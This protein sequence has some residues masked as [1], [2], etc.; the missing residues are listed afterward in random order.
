M[1]NEILITGVKVT[2]QKSKAR[3]ILKNQVITREELFQQRKKKRNIK[4]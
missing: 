4:P 1:S 2:Q 3:S